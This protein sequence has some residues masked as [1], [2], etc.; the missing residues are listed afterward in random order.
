[1]KK[2]YIELGKSKIFFYVDT[3]FFNIKL[4]K[5][6]ILNSLGNLILLKGKKR[7]NLLVNWKYLAIGWAL[8][9]F[10]EATLYWIIC[11]MVEIICRMVRYLF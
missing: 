9:Y 3:L 7:Y 1:M 6:P 2:T 10:R 11:G 5:M 4:G 8:T